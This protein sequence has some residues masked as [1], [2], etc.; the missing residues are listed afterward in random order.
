MKIAMSLAKKILDIPS[1]RNFFERLYDYYKITR[2]ELDK[3]YFGKDIKL[4]NLLQSRTYKLKREFNEG[5]TSENSIALRSLVK[6]IAT[7]NMQIVEIGSWT[8]TST[9]VLAKAVGESGKVFA[10]DHWLGSVGERILELAKETDIYFVFKQNM[11]ANKLWNRV[12]PLVMDSA[13]ASTIFKDEIL[14]LVFI[15]AD[16]RFESV[17]QDIESWLPKLKVGGILCGKAYAESHSG[18]RKAVDECLGGQHLI[19]GDSNIWYYKKLIKE[20]Q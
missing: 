3:E 18:I 16:H 7:K 11:I 12:H 8:G 13:T 6:T 15:D 19:K 1:V 5:V 2:L 20:K 9:T 17:K 4:Y 14:D 10:V